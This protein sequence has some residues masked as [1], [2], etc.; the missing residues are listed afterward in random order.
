MALPLFVAN[1]LGTWQ[2]PMASLETQ[3]DNRNLSALLELESMARKVESEKALQFLVVNESRRLLNYRQAFLVAT[4]GD[5]LHIETASSLSVVDRDSPMMTWLENF[6]SGHKE[7]TTLQTISSETLSAE[8]KRRF[9]EYAFQHVIWCPLTLN[10]GLMVGGLWLSRETPW[11]P[12]ELILLERLCET[13]AHAWVALVGKKSFTRIT[14]RKQKIIAGVFAALLIVSLLPVRLST[15]APAEIVA[16][17]P[18]II[19]APIDGVIR[20]ILVAPNMP[21]VEGDALFRYEDTNLR[22]AHEIALQARNVAAARLRQASQGAFQDEASRGQVALLQAELS[23][24]ETELAYARELLS[25]VEVK[26][27]QDGLLVY[28]EASDWVGKPVIVGERIME[29]VDPERVQFRINLPVDDAIILSEGSEVDVFLHANPLTSIQATISTTSYNAYL[30]PENILAYR[31][32]AAFTEVPDKPRIGLQGSAR[33][34]GERVTLFF[35]VFRRPI[36]ALRQ[37]FGI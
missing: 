28:S 15:I 36:S 34:Y 18:S 6:L 12:N 23:L 9:E 35:Y 16:L 29:V 27:G 17:E 20:E 5:S 1:D 10:D 26:T 30:T 4:E 22:N 7:L 2:Y 31:I 19:S 21:V 8:D 25:Q 3:T 24:K 33:V 32:E 13:Y 37:F 14:G 11:Q